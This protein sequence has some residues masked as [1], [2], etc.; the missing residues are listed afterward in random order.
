MSYGAFYN[1]LHI[2]TCKINFGLF[3]TVTLVKLIAKETCFARVPS[4]SLPA[5]HQSCDNVYLTRG[6]FGPNSL[7]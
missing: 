5:I 4:D 3:I 2:K 1:D 6:P 7:T